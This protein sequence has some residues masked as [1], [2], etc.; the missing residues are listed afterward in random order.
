LKI[1]RSLF[2][3]LLSIVIAMTIPV[4]LYHKAAIGRT[5]INNEWADCVLPANGCSEL[6]CA[7]L[8]PQYF[9]GGCQGSAQ[10]ASATP[11]S[12]S[13]A[14]PVSVRLQIFTPLLSPQ[15]SLEGK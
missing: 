5:E 7:K 6:I 9:L 13:N 11:S 4:K 2:I 1:L 8:L 14:F 15:A 12:A 3:V 10:F